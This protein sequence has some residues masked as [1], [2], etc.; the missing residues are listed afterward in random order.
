M[1]SDLP[2]VTNPAAEQDTVRSRQPRGKL[3]SFVFVVLCLLLVYSLIV[4][5]P[6]EIARWYHAAARERYLDGDITAALTNLDRG[7]KWSPESPF[8][9]LERAAWKL[10]QKDLEGSL[11]D[12][13]RVVEIAPQ[14]LNPYFLRSTVYNRMGHHQEAVADLTTAFKMIPSHQHDQ[15]HGVLNARAYIRALGKIELENGLNDVQSAIALLE[16]DTSEESSRLRANYLDTRGYLHY[17]LGKQD[18][19]L[20]DLFWAVTLAEQER[21]LKLARLHFTEVDSRKWDAQAIQLDHN[22]AVLYHHRGLIYQAL[23]REELAEI[24]LH[25]GDELGYNPDEG[26]E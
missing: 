5:A 1:S 21:S 7:L 20:K 16:K 26:I 19:A 23:G 9:Y 4:E 12:C 13:N 3:R 18:K 10:E 11:A 8:M 22:L 14:L 17:L 6:R 15:L 2:D 24:D 25:R